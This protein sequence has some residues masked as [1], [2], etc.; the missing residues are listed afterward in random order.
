MK[1]VLP[2]AHPSGLMRF[3]DVT[4][5]PVKGVLLGVLIVYMLGIFWYAL[6]QFSTTD[7]MPP[8]KPINTEAL[9]QLGPFTVRVKVGM[10]IKH[11]PIFD[12][13]KNT[14]QVDAIVWFDFNGDEANLDTIERFSFD[15]G[16][17]VYKSPPEIKVTGTN[18]F[19][20]YNVIF[21]LK[22]NLQFHRFPLE[23]HRLAIMMANEFVTPD[24]MIFVVGASSFELF[25]KEAPA[26]WHFGDLSVDAGI[27]PLMLDKQDAE[28]KAES[29]R[30]LFIANIVKSSSRR[31]LLVFLP[32]YSMIILALLSFLM[33]AGNTG[34]KIGLASTALTG[35]LGYRFVLEQVVPQVGYFTTTDS[36][37]LLLLI[38]SC[39]NFCVQLFLTRHIMLRPG[40]EAA[41]ITSERVSSWFFVVVLVFLMAAT[42]YLVLF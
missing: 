6:G 1:K 37:Y 5:T 35:L 18:I 36:V 11:F 33:N 17:I 12:V 39:V 30:A 8:L 34:G 16:K 15:N 19:V 40:D 14:F 24:E 13:S 31:A 10:F 25:S 22:T 29:P 9:K 2:A 28:K 41:L 27:Q 32:L 38:V 21:E 26:G 23:D 42:T 7:V 4:K 3:F 20:R